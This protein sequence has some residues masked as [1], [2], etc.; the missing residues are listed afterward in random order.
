MITMLILAAAVLTGET[1]RPKDSIYA[2]GEK[3]EAVF[4]ASGLAAGEKRT[5]T[6]RVEDAAKRELL[7][8]KLELTA[9]EKGGFTQKLELPA[10][11]RGFY[12][13]LA[14]AGKD[15]ALPKV[16]SRPAGTL[17]YAVV[18]DAMKRRVP[19]E[20][21]AFL[22]MIPFY[23]DT[24][25][26]RSV[27]YWTG[28]RFG[29]SRDTPQ[30][31]R[32][33]RPSA[34]PGVYVDYG[35]QAICGHS[36]NNLIPFFSEEGKKWLKDF[37]LK[38]TWDIF[39]RDSEEGRRHFADAALAYVKAAVDQLPSD[40][41]RLVVE[42]Y[43]EPD[44]LSPKPEFIVEAQK[45]VWEKVHPVYPDV[46][47]SGPG[48]S[49]IHNLNYHRR[50]FELGIGRYLNAYHVHPYTGY[51]PESNDFLEN[52]RAIRKM[53]AEHCG[54]REIPMF[55]TEAGKSGDHT[56]EYADM[57]G[58]IRTMLILLGEGFANN[59]GFYASDYG[60][61]GG[62]DTDG[63]Y[64]Y[65]YNLNLPKTRFGNERY[66]P[67]PIFAALAGFSEILDGYRPVVCIDTLGETAMGYAYANAADP[68]E[69]A[70][71]LWDYGGEK[72]SVSIDTGV[73]RVKLCDIYGNAKE[74]ATNGGFLDLEIGIEPVYVLGVS[75]AKWGRDGGETKKN[76]K[77]FVKAVPP[78]G[79]VA[80][81]V[82]DDH[83][84]PLVTLVC[85]NVTEKPVEATASVRIRGIPEAHQRGRVKLP[86]RGTGEI[87]FRLTGFRPDPFRAYE[88]ESAVEDAAGVETKRRS[89]VNF[90]TAAY[91][92]DF[93]TWKPAFHRYRENA[94]FC[95]GKFHRGPS[96]CTFDLGVGWN[97]KYLMFAFDVQDDVYRQ[98]E[99][100]FRTFLGDCIQIGLAKQ[101]L[102][103]PTANDKTDRHT[104]AMSELDFALTKNGPEIYRTYSF[105]EDFFRSGTGSDDG[106]VSREECPFTVE[107]LPREGGGVLLRYRMAIPWNY[108]LIENP[109]PG[110]S[111]LFAALVGDRDTAGESMTMLEVFKAKEGRPKKFGRITLGAR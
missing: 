82:G 95:G 103:K 35:G 79:V 16:G 57:C 15:L 5:L 14:D 33:R 94:F 104:V 9:D 31:G 62:H 93:A 71:A 6:V 59:Y 58:Q 17:S 52:V 81:R 108:M 25:D 22:A 110:T 10:A 77:G 64:G 86:A 2:I 63:D 80:D 69:L 56:V 47:I 100:G 39:A 50:L 91:V 109:K 99:T 30:P 43:S 68:K 42:F 88:L 55:G 105:D 70:L 85:G 83:G 8:R 34:R 53:I 37:K 111:C 75:P 78:V 27:A 97:E 21:D 107:K 19:K 60:N 98:T 61:D 32:S 92:P 26:R 102:L 3:P 67:R 73:G 24:P 36:L 84:T 1:S 54:G 45:L 72:S 49:N 4:T 12:R 89:A 87:T 40:R 96:D 48:L 28:A 38:L 101:L 41:R 20:E 90:L 23:P 46:L 76:G 44:L 74:T 11:N 51:P 66:S 106:I 13:V 7:T 18:I 65:T 29:M